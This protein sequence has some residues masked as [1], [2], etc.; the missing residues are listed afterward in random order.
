MDLPV[1]TQRGFFSRFDRLAFWAGTVV[2]FLVYFFTCAPSV[3]L[4]DSGE[5]AVAGDYAGVPHP[6]GY[7]SWTACAWVFARLLGLVSFR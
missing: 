4:E 5:L 3:T 6:P 2:S 7:P 1:K